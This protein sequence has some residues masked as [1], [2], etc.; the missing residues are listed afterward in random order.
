MKLLL[1]AA[2]LCGLGLT[3]PAQALS[4]TDSTV[5]SANQFGENY[6]GWMWN[7]QGSGT[8]TRNA[9]NMYYSTSPDPATPAFVNSGNDSSAEISIALTSGVYDFVIFGEQTGAPT[10]DPALHYVLNLYFDGDQTMPGITGLTGATCVG[11]CTASHWNGLD[12]FGNSGAQESGA[13]S[14]VSGSTTVTLTGFSWIAD[15]TIDQVWPHYA[16]DYFGNYSGTPDFVGHLQLTVSEVPLPAAGWVLIGAL[17]TLV[18][19]GRRASVKRAASK[20]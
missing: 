16:G 3:Q 14:Y 11:V 7:T 2:A 1:A 9:W 5:F 4:L 17:G 20:G 8:D 18:G 12:L 10:T 19:A 6:N 13:L 15:D